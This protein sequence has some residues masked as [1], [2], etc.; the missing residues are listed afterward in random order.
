MYLRLSNLDLKE[1]NIMN[2]AIYGANLSGFYATKLMDLQNN[3]IL[4]YIDQNPENRYEQLSESIAIYENVEVIPKEFLE[5][6]ELI[7]VALGD[8]TTANIVKEEIN[9]Y[10]KGKVFTVHEGPYMEL[11]DLMSRDHKNQ[12]LIETGFYESEK[13][14]QSVDGSF[15]PIPWLTFPL[16]E[17]LKERVHNNLRVFEWGSGNSTLWWEQY[18]QSVVAVEHDRNWFEQISQKLDSNKSK[19]LF[20]EL[21]YD[22]EYSKSISEYS[23]IDIVVVDGRDR[24]NCAKNS[25]KSLSHKGIII[26]DDTERAEYKEG[27]EYLK[28]QGF[29]M[30]TF[31]GLKAIYGATSHSSIFYRDNNCLDI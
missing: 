11:Y 26:W 10:F 28:T 23:E 5:K 30:L 22:G 7:V 12:Y 21:H 14:R 1:I 17:L 25:I 16:V 19:I 24:V 4:F 3:E 15:N 2:C 18:T 20:K 9:C 6:V 29:K 13:I 8:E 31:S 27:I